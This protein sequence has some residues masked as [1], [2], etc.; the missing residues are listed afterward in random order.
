MTTVDF[1]PIDAEEKSLRV[2]V[3]TVVHEELPVRLRQGQVLVLV[4][5]AQAPASQAKSCP[6]E[7][8]V[9]SF[10]RQTAIRHETLG[11]ARRGGSTSANELP[12]T[13][14]CEARNGICA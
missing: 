11:G 1:E 8:K 6:V 12:S 4:R 13:I 9:A 3:A 5:I 7:A 2:F 14:P 10:P